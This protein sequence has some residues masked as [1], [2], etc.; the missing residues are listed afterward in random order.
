MPERCDWVPLDIPEYVRYHDEEWGAPLHDDRRFFELLCL[1]GAQAGLSW[2]TVLRRREAYRQA[3]DGFDPLKVRS[4]GEAEIER[5]LSN[6]G[7]IR[8]RRKIESA[9]RNAACFTALQERWGSFDAYIWH[10]TEG[11]SLVGTWR[12]HTELPAVTPLSELI[13]REL[14]GEGFS[15]VGPTILYAFLQ[16]S[17]VVNDHT[18]S[19]FRR[20][21][22]RKL[23]EL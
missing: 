10:F 15:F 16:S 22:C 3:F 4:Y 5:L 13:S 7:I 8:N 19:C 18:L 2:L 23:A 20:E 17:G 14:K 9:V 6:S 11:R 21:E 1:E 12:T